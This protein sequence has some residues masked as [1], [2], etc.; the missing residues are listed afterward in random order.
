MGKSPRTSDGILWPTRR[1]T[2]DAVA[3]YIEGTYNP[4]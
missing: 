2:K 1:A 3:D 4:Y